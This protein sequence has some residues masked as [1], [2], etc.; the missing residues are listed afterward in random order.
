MQGDGTWTE[1]QYVQI[2]NIKTQSKM[3]N[4]MEG[5]KMTRLYKEETRLWDSKD[6]KTVVHFRPDN[7]LNIN[8]S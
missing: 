8:I 1:F 5:K 7:P 2:T 3:I 6:E 4:I